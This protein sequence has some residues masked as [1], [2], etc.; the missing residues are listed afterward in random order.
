MANQNPSKDMELMET[1]LTAWRDGAPDNKFGGYSLAEYQTMVE[2][3]KQTRVEREEIEFNRMQNIA[4]REK[5]DAASLATREKIVLAVLGDPNFGPDS[6]L[7]EM[8]GYKRKSAYRSG[9]TRKKKNPPV[10]NLL[11]NE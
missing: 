6:A 9:L 3:S 10:D 8:M 7:Y 11:N 1:V 2:K 4:K 5:D